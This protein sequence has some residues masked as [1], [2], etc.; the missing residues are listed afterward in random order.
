MDRDKFISI[1]T[2]GYEFL[3]LQSE[4]MP[5]VQ[6]ML[7]KF[8]NHDE[9]EIWATSELDLGSGQKEKLLIEVDSFS[10]LYLEFT[11][12]VLFFSLFDQETVHMQIERIA[13]AVEFIILGLTEIEL[14]LSEIDDQMSLENNHVVETFYLQ[15]SQLMSEDVINKRKDP[16]DVFSYKILKLKR[17]VLVYQTKKDESKVSRNTL[18]TQEHF[19]IAYNFLS[20]YALFDNLELKSRFYAV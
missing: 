7:L 12:N 4:D 15:D 1:L 17:D 18:M 16:K 6:L 11:D 2:D 14:F 19:E 8:I 9:N 20:K 13:K 3:N 5:L 10:L